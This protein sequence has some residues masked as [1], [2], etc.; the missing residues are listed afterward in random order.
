MKNIFWF[1]IVALLLNSCIKKKDKIPTPRLNRYEAGNMLLPNSNKVGVLWKNENFVSQ[2]DATQDV[3]VKDLAVKDSTFYTCG[4]IQIGTATKNTQ[5]MMWVNNVPT[6]LPSNSYNS[7]ANAIVV[8][9]GN[10]YVIGYE[11][12]FGMPA[13]AILWINGVATR[14]LP[15]QIYNIGIDMI[16]DGTDI[17]TLVHQTY[18]FN[19][20]TSLLIVKN[21]TI[22][23]TI[24]STDEIFGRRLAKSGNNFYIA[25]SQFDANNSDFFPKLW[26]NQNSLLINGLPSCELKGITLANDSFFACGFRSDINLKYEPCFWYNFAEPVSSNMGSFGSSAEDIVWYNNQLNSL[27][28][29]DQ[30]GNNQFKSYLLVTATANYLGSSITQLTNPNNYPTLAKRIVVK[31][32]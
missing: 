31:L 10:V 18:A 16:I 19:N 4:E 30:D 26:K 22:I 2:S 8:A 12:D 24:T 25:G 13:V 5:A 1:A 14:L 32:N 3:T 29:Y 17:Y 7:S 20:N 27:Q 21:G 28:N 9:N 23:Q 11:S 6:L 15:A